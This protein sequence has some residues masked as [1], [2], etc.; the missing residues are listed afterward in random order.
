VRGI[1][2]TR[3]GAKR[4]EGQTRRSFA[5]L[6][7]SIGSLQDTMKNPTSP[8][9][10]SFFQ[11]CE[12]SPGVCEL[13]NVDVIPS[14]LDVKFSNGSRKPYNDPCGHAISKLGVL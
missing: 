2:T 13:H 9:A 7:L 6:T 14:A 1:N 10:N 3:G 8:P 4:L 11:N 12:F 5:E